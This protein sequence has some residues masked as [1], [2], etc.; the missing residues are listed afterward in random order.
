MRREVRASKRKTYAG[1]WQQR[2]VRGKL[3]GIDDGHIR[4]TRFK[5][6]TTGLTSGFWVLSSSSCFFT[7]SCWL[8]PVA[9]SIKR[10]EERKRKRGKMGLSEPRDKLSTLI[11]RS[12]ISTT[13][14]SNHCLI[15][16]PH[17]AP[18]SHLCRAF[19]RPPAS[20]FQIPLGF[21]SAFI[22]FCT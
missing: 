6:L 19:F 10:M 5:V 11:R 12:P 17:P 13:N 7:G 22:H 14:N 8:V 20:Q 21:R 16:L 1:T 15:R 3:C 18:A 4:G 9:E 2:H